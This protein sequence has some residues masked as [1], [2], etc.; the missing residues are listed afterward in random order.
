MEKSILP[1]L[2][3]KDIVLLPNN[4]M[5]LE[6]VTE[7][8]KSLISLAESYYNK[9]I[10]IITGKDDLDIEE[11]NPI[12][13]V[14]GYISMK[15]DMPNKKTRIV[16]NGLKR[17]K[18]SKT[19]IENDI[20]VGE[21]TPIEAELEYI[22][23]S[24]YK[25]SVLNS[26][27]K[28]LSENEDYVNNISQRINK[29]LKVSEI[30]DILA[31]ELNLPLDRELAYLEE[32]DVS[33]RALMIL[34]DL[35]NES[36]ILELEQQIEEKVSHNIDEAQKEYFLN[37]RIKVMQ[38]ELGQDE[39]SEIEELKNRVSK[40]KCPKKVK[41]KLYN[42]IKK[43][44]KTPSNSP[45]YSMIKTYIDTV[46]SL[47]WSYKTADNDD[48]EDALHILNDS[49]YGLDDVKKRIIEYLALTKMTNKNNIPIICLVGP[50]GVG[51]TTLAIN[52][53][54]AMKRKHA[55]ITVGGVNDPADIIG[56]RRTYIGSSP[57][58]IIEGMKKAGSI[59]PVF[60]IDEIDK[61][62]K[63][64][65]GDPASALLEV[66][67]KSQN[68]SFVDNYIEEEYDLSN[69]LF[70]C[71]AN[72]K[73]QIPIELLDRLEIIELSSY[74]VYEKL[75]ICKS[76]IIPKMLKDYNLEKYN[77]KFYDDTIINI[78]NCYTKEAG[79]R[80]L[81]RL[82][83]NILRKI[84]KDIISRKENIK[85][86]IEVKDL[87][88]YLSLP[89]YNY[90]LNNKEYK[91][92]E[93]NAMSYTPFGG[94]ILKLEVNILKGNGN[95]ITTGSLGEVFKESCS[96]AIS[97]IKANCKEFGI[98]YKKLS[99]SDIHLHVP[100]GA[101]KKDGPSA[102]CAITTAI[103]SSVK[104]TPISNKISMTGEIT[105]HGDVLEIGGLK[106]KIIG[107]KR[108]KVEKIFIP[109]ANKNDLEEIDD[110]VKQGIRFILV[111]N[112]MEIAKELGL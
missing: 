7:E 64:I 24:A 78:I 102:G 63:D 93:V 106:E 92:G 47:P 3:L 21:L 80:E 16:I 45:D 61:M 66:L 111:D 30:T 94:D 99:E 95:I 27:E 107:A 44:E 39:Y 101:V 34:D 46:L 89:K 49:H 42:E 14:I 81:E 57:G 100:E 96:V 12:I 105:I 85:Y 56:H 33:N 13:G 22:E 35:S 110:E 69:V 55:K 90:Y 108:S 67:D 38:K 104:N 48:L 10:L 40:I 73:E 51:K 15:L 23:E 103:I 76:H 86:D 4:E 8:D 50:P 5:R 77:I 58:R 43:Y 6:F 32:V 9:H 83:G 54:N 53:A 25:R 98:D 71:T 19:Y 31:T 2:V 74:T 72:Y 52:I 70:I 84:V 28:F 112:Y 18:V 97:Y 41:D 37:E 60:I 59:N 29:T 11:N 26:L 82:I 62:T 36:K 91:S 65:K 68:K 87:T 75:N 88:Y 109:S 79:V 20:L 1:I 17:A